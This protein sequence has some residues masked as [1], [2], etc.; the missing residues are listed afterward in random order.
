[1]A[2]SATGR[3][4]RSRLLAR[5]R[6][7]GGDAGARR[8]RRRRHQGRGAGARRRGALSRRDRR[9]IAEVR[10]RQP[11]VPRAQPQQAFSIALD[12]GSPA[13][14]KAR[15]ADGREVRRRRAQFPPRRD[16]AS[17]ASATRHLK[18]AQSRHHLLRVHRLRP[19]GPAGA[20]RRQRSRAAGAQRPDEHHR[21]AR[22][23]AG[24]RAARRS[25]DLHGSLALVIGRSRRAVPSRAHRRRP[26]G[27]DVAAAELGAS[28]ELLLQRVLDGRHGAQADG[29][30][31]PS[32]RAEPGVSDRRRQRRHH[33]A[34][35]RDVAALRRGARASRRSTGRSCDACSTGC[36]SAPS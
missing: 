28:D 2:E 36:G 8:P 17:G 16:G 31:Q 10:R 26:G 22:P 19:R 4:P 34:E 6:G 35:R 1:M 18:R 12:L 20:H 32:E 24:A 23:A 7:A 5:V 30:R 21:R 14:R 3:H 9:G 33:R 11:V 29:H 15:A 25:I 13:G 27:R